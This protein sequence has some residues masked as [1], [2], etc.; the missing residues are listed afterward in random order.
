MLEPELSS[1]QQC[2]VSCV[3]VCLC[4]VCWVCW[5]LGVLGVVLCVVLCVGAGAGQEGT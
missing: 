5:V 2:A 4:W 1:I 3:C